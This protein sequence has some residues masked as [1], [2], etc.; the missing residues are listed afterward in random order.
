MKKK[1]I[2][3]IVGLSVL[4]GLGTIGVIANENEKTEVTNMV[5]NSIE[6]VK[7]T[8]F[9]IRELTKN[10]IFIG[11]DEGKLNLDKTLKRQEM[12]VL[13]SRLMGKE[14]E[15]KNWNREGLTF[16]DVG[17]DN[18]AAGYI[19]WAKD[20][21]ITKGYSEEWFGY[22]DTLTEKQ[23]GIF[24]LRV[25]GYENVEMDNV[26]EI[27]ELAGIAEEIGEGEI[28]RGKVGIMIY[29]SL[30]MYM[31]EDAGTLGDKI[32]LEEIMSY[33]ERMLAEACARNG[34]EY[35]SKGESNGWKIIYVNNELS[36]IEV[37]KAAM[38]KMDRGSWIGNYVIVTMDGKLIEV[39]YYNDAPE[40][41]QIKVEEEIIYKA[42]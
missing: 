39:I 4:I 36:E 5:T 29:N 26:K 41:Y 42:Q 13:I 17:K 27:G 30:H 19:A 38:D 20:N 14:E 1:G 31:G 8:D 25:L 10:K 12:V 3:G 9:R 32:G 28:V 2:I 6:V 37:S 15:A 35:L 7:E 18:W 11:D 40:I 16:E 21:N 33:E 34:M 22:D 23:T 24:L